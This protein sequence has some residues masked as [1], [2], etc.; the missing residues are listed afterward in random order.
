[1]TLADVLATLETQGALK[2]S[3]VPAMKTSLKYLAAALGHSSPEQCPLD[4]ALRQEATWGKALESHFQ[5]LEAQGRTISAYTRRNVRNDIRKVL[6]L[7]EELGLLPKPLP[8]SLLPKP[9]RRPFRL[10][11]RLASPY[12]LTYSRND[13]L[14]HYR[15][16]QAEWPQDIQTGWQDYLA[17]C[18][19]GLRQ[20][21]LT[22]YGR[23]MGT[24]LGY[25]V[26][27]V[28]RTPTWDDLFQVAALRAFVLWH[29]ARLGRSLSVHGRQVATIITTIANVVGHSQAPA[30]ADFRN[31]L[32]VPAPLHTKRAHWISLAQLEE[33]AESCLADGRKPVVIQPGTRHGGAGRAS[34][35]QRG[36]IL[37]LFVRVPLRQ[38]NVR[39]M[40]LEKNLWQDPTTGHWH[41]HFAGDELKIAHRGAE[42]NKYELNLSTYRPEFIPVLEDFLTGYRPRLPG[43]Q[44]S[45]F[46]FLT[47]RGR[48]FNEQSLRE[49]LMLAVGMRT[50]KRFYP[51]LV[52]TIWATEYLTSTPA[53]DWTT[54]AVML[55]DKVSTVMARYH[56]L[57]DSAHHP[58]ASD[59]LSRVLKG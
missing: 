41:L 53:P 18:G 6:K 3:R 55:G 14:R 37:K 40:Q 13:G 28:G 48:P 17:R 11:Q 5:A 35:F 38:R 33:V 43:A 21:T 56:D 20:S 27:I 15:L 19:L 47:H 59:F 8:S 58:K 2:R 50:G 12:K 29:A 45:P 34:A 24:Y 25:Q 10:Q 30:L 32:P 52:R 7:A 51:H 31:T 4:G 23:C 49:E 44:T 16:P 22:T 36:V 42:I 46:V 39:E 57:E 9:Q 54:A 1:M 26:H